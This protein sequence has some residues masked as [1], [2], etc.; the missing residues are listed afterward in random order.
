MLDWAAVHGGYIMTKRFGFPLLICAA[1]LVSSSLNSAHAVP[2]GSSCDPY[3]KQCDAGLLC[4]PLL[5]MT[6]GICCARFEEPRPAVKSQGRVLVWKCVRKFERN[7]L[8]MAA[9]CSLRPGG[10]VGKDYNTHKLFCDPGSVCTQMHVEYGSYISQYGYY[11][12]RRADGHAY[13]CCRSGIE[14][15]DPVGPPR[16]STGLCKPWA[17]R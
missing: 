10:V 14:S 13:S 4:A 16:L 15:C 2:K 11:M 1:F 5:N 8:T 7:A 6:T 9:F 3:T 17:G 12:C